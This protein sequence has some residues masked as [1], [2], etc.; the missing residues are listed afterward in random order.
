[1]SEISF[2]SSIR[3]VSSTEFNKLISKCGK[4]NFVDFP[5]TIEDTK[6]APDVFTKNIADCSACVISNGQNAVM[7]HLSPENSNNHA[8]SIVLQK[9]RNLIDLKDPNLQAILIGSKNTKKSQD[10]YT[11]FK[12]LF[13]QLNIPYSTLKNSNKP[14]N[15]AYSSTSD[16]LLVSNIEIDKKLKKGYTPKDALLSSFENI[17]IANCDTLE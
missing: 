3:G 8:F 11:K 4:Q 6:I 13:E 17:N 5:W 16:E 15:I 9:L 1:M 2:T 7:M 10:I 12:E 14:A